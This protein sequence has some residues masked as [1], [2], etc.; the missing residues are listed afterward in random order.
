M[1]KYR[2]KRED[3]QWTLEIKLYTQFPLI[4]PEHFVDY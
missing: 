3:L 4:S 1:F 2:L